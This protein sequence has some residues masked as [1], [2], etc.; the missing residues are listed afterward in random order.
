MRNQSRDRSGANATRR[1]RSPAGKV[2]P[3]PVHKTSTRLPVENAVHQVNKEI[4]TRF[5][6]KGSVSKVEWDKKEKLTLF[7]DDEQKL[8]SVIDILQNKLIKR[9]ISIKNLEYEKLEVAVSS[10]WRFYDR[11][12]ITFKKSPAR[13]R[14]GSA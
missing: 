8:K 9:G 13:G 14:A 5:D 12:A 4:A 2:T 10:V 11:H 6:F 7:S 1:D 3:P